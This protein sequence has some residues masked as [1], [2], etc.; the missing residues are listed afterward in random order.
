MKRAVEEGMSPSVHQ[1]VNIP[2][3][4]RAIEEGDS[5]SVRQRVNMEIEEEM[6]VG[7]VVGRVPVQLGLQYRFSEEPEEFSLDAMSGNVSTSTVIDREALR[8]S[9]FNLVVQSV[10]STKHL[11]E[12][13][14][15]V[16]DVNDNSPSFPHPVI[17]V[18]FSEADQQGRQVI[19][20][21]ATDPDTTKNGIKTYKIVGGNQQ[22]RFKLIQMLEG[23]K[24][25]IYLENQVVLDREDVANYK[26]NISAE[27]Y[28][29]RKGYMTANISIKDVNDHGPIFDQSD[30][31]AVVNETAPPGTTVSQ[32]QAT[33]GDTGLNGEVTYHIDPQSDQLDQLHINTQT[34]VITTTKMLSCSHSCD[35]SAEGCD[36][37]SCVIQLTARDR[38]VDHQRSGRAYLTISL[39]DENNHS[40]VIDYQFKGGKDYAEIEENANVGQTVALIFMSDDDHGANAET[41][42]KIIK[43]NTKKHFKLSEESVKFDK[44]TRVELLV[45][46]LLDREEIAMYNLTLE[47]SDQGDPRRVTVSNMLIIVNDV[48]DHH[49]EFERKSYHSDLSEFS[50]V[51]SF[52][53]ALTALDNDTGINAEISYFITS[54]NDRDWFTINKDTGLITTKSHLDRETSARV[55]LVVKAQDGNSKPQ[56]TTVQLEVVIWDENEA[57]DLSSS[58]IQLSISEGVGADTRLT[59][60]SAIDNDSGPNGTVTYRLT[61]ESMARYTDMFTIGLYNGE[62][63]FQRSL[64]R[65]EYDHIELTVTATDGGQPPLT[66]IQV[67]EVNVTDVNDNDPVLYPTLYHVH[68][69][70]GEA[71]S[72]NVVQVTGHDEDIGQHGRVVYSIDNG[73]DNF[74]IDDVTGWI[75]TTRQMDGTQR[76]KH[77]I[78]VSGADGGG[79]LTSHTA[80]VMVIV[81]NMETLPLAFTESAYQMTTVE[82]TGGEDSYQERTVG[83]VEAVPADQ[84]AY[85]IVSGDP[86]GRF[87]IHSQTGVITT[88]SHIDREQTPYHELVIVAERLTSFAEVTVNVTVDDLN[89]NS[90]WY[91][92]DEVYALLDENSPYGYEVYLAAARDED[93]GVNGTL[94]YTLTQPNPLFSI[95]SDTG[96][97]RLSRPGALSLDTSHQV[98][99]R[100]VDG[101]GLSSQVTLYI[102]IRDVN[103]HTPLF[104]QAS[105]EASIDE[106][107]KVNDHFVTVLAND[108]DL[109]ENGRVT[110]S[111]VKGNSEYIFGIFPDGVMY[112]ANKLDRETTDLYL[113]TIKACDLGF[114]PRCSL[115]NVSIHV[116]D[117]NDNAPIF[118]N[119]TYTM[120]IVEGM[121]VGTYV[122]SVYAIDYDIGSNA[123]LLF[124]IAGVSNEF[125]IHPKSGA[126]KNTK[127][128]DREEL[129]DSTKADYISL[130]VIVKD[131]GTP[132]LQ[133]K[134]QVKVIINDINDNPPVFTKDIYEAA[135]FENAD[136]DTSVAQVTAIDSD[137]G[138]NADISYTIIEANHWEVFQMNE[139]TGQVLL[140]KP[141]DREAVD[142]YNLLIMAM[143]RGSP[144][145]NT[146]T[147]LH[148]DVWDTNDNKPAFRNVQQPI[149]VPETTIKD[150]VITQL[151]A[152]DNDLGNNAAVR[153][154]I[155]DGN[156]DVTFKIDNKNGKVKLASSLDY[157]SVQSYTLN[158]TATDSGSPPLMTS[159]LLVV[160]V[161]DVNDNTPRFSGSTIVREIR[162]G[163]SNGTSVGTVIAT[164]ADSRANGEVR[165]HIKSQEP[166][167]D[168]FMIDSRSGLIRTRGEIDR[169]FTDNY[170][171]TVQAVDQALPVETRRSAEKLVSV[172]ITDVND[173]APIFISMNA[174][175]V[176]ITHPSNTSFT[177]IRTYDPD[178]GL[179]GQVKYQITADQ[180]FGVRE[181]TGDLF[182]HS[183]FVGGGLFYDITVKAQDQGMADSEGQKSALFQLTV[184]VTSEGDGPTFTQTG[185][186]G[187]VT[188]NM[189]EDTS[190]ATVSA[191][192]PQGDVEYYLTGITSDGQLQPRYF[193]VHHSSG[194]IRTTMELDRENGFSMFTL[195]IYAVNKVAPTPRVKS[196]QV[197][198]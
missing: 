175:P 190:V 136:I 85:H 53:A 3:E 36:P 13:I 155:V 168:H 130:E 41:K 82:D 5:P 33:D 38:G 30:Y 20:D 173:N 159:M 63:T 135:L 64:D 83:R 65:E 68:M 195:E 107:F 45:A 98:V 77:V 25:I 119:K 31:F 194:I 162:E 34:G 188:E 47:A 171:L 138:V 174:V 72:T 26:L 58:H 180:I 73:G 140:R 44:Y 176:S 197:R 67:I 14:I 198:L 49:P 27:D 21:T 79:R 17:Q 186:S 164:D 40:P 51:G 106:N 183:P 142:E 178:D 123:E 166:P 145:Y 191:Y 187:Q 52:V 18:E 179:K 115:A 75:S 149:T 55:V 104:E 78:T 101:G 99:I 121:D 8:E 177:R 50:P 57:P 132:Q 54:G 91:E 59:R 96:M 105:Y 109:A 71:S 131:S 124:A 60:V 100:A 189:A 87:T 92:L 35:V 23:S 94:T 133:S 2:I 169:E 84:V 66:S 9:V 152:L 6:P 16:L 97:I 112:V 147:E 29:S 39:L 76:G 108:A 153:Y 120:R 90:P 125:T 146:T 89:D 129:L 161:E 143:D 148:I 81:T 118:S 126:I 139:S 181:E 158:V 185:Y 137:H 113:L 11:I 62:V 182:L 46:S 134:A 32:V 127:V 114:E 95:D 88:S 111:I 156:R 4:K 19:I 141:L 172:F 86:S 184:F 165:Y 116:M 160:Q 102:T 110:Y 12:V 48:N 10:P 37:N 1:R 42:L 7:T 43:G 150:H 167:G 117:T 61:P 193:K 24:P 70:E 80:T 28:G 170:K 144:P 56:T 192:D 196:V 157:E 128:F 22:N 15:E 69:M 151:I 74:A 103:D 93:N 154:H 163:V 122:G